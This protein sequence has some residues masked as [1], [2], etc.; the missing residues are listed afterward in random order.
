MKEL[1]ILSG[2]GGTGKTSMTGICLALAQRSGNRTVLADADVD[3]ADLFLLTQPVPI[4]EEDFTSG[5]E[6]HINPERCTGCGR[7]FSVCRFD[8]IRMLES[9]KARIAETGCEGCAVCAHVCPVHAIDLVERHCGVTWT[10]DT[11]FGRMFHARLDPAGENSGKL[12]TL[13]RQKA[14]EYARSCGADWLIVDGPPGLGCPV[15]ASMTDADAILAVAEPGVSS[16]HDLVRLLELARHF[17]IPAMLV[18]NKWDIAPGITVTIED[19][20]RR[21]GARPVGRIPWT[22]SI[23]EAQLAGQTLPEHLPAG[24]IH[25]T[26]TQIWEKI[27][28]TMHT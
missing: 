22:A 23:I 14:R 28:Q 26:I 12:V 7:C 18:I 8:A 16:Q 6:A 10:S 25:N 1:V 9:G 21:L 11:R 15:I 3:A 2:K 13:L 20:A 27:C 5:V 19:E 24:D 4:E 17:G